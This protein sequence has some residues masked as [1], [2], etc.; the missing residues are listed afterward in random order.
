MEGIIIS[1]Y[2]GSNNDN[3]PQNKQITNDKKDKNE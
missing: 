1:D 3:F 2:F